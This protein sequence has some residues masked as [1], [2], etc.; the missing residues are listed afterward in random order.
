MVCALQQY[1]IDPKVAHN[2]VIDNEPI[3]NKRRNE[4]HGY[5]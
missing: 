4:Q 1:L 3:E 2:M 5:E